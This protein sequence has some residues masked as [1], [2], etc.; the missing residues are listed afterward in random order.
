MGK[1]EEQHPARAM[2]LGRGSLVSARVYLTF[3]PSPGN[4]G[5]GPLIWVTWSLLSGGPYSISSLRAP[6]GSEVQRDLGDPLA[7]QGVQVHKVPLEQQ[8]R[9][10]SR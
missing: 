5:Q 6:L 3:S 4:R 10:A 7:P 8:A 1:D 9:K 2:G